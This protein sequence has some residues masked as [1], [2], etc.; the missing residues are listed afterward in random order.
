MAMSLSL[1]VTAGAANLSDYS[2]S[3]KVTDKYATAVDFASQLG[4]LEGFD[5]GKYHPQGTLT[6][7]Q[8]ATMVYRMTTADVADVYTANFA[9]GAAEAFSDTAATAW[10]A[11]YVGYAADAELLKGLGDGTYAPNDALTGY[12]ALAA[13]LRGVG[14]DEPGH[15]FVGADWTVEV[16]KVA[17]EAG[18]LSGISNVD[19][20]KPITREVA[21]QMIYNIMFA[22]MVEYTPA[23][24]Y[25]EW[26][27]GDIDLA[28]EEFNIVSDKDGDAANVAPWGRPATIWVADDGSDVT[29]AVT[30]E[31]TPVATY[32]TGVNECDLSKELGKT[33]E[34]TAVKWENGGKGSATIQATDVKNDVAGT[35][36]G[37]LTEVYKVGSAYE[38]VEIQTWLAEVDAV[39]KATFDKNGHVTRDAKTTLKAYDNQNVAPEVTV[40]F[41][42]E[43]E[44]FAEDSYVLMN[45]SWFTKAA[46]TVTVGDSVYE[47]ELEAGVDTG[48][49]NLTAATPVATGELTAYNNTTKTS[50]IGGTTYD[51]AQ[52]FGMGFVGETGKTYDVYVD[53]YG[54]VIGI[55]V[56]A[57]VYT[58]GIV[59]EMAWENS[60]QTLNTAKAYANLLDFTATPDKGVVMAGVANE[61]A[62]KGYDKFISA[63]KAYAEGAALLAER[64]VSTIVENNGD[65]YNAIYKFETLSDGSKVIAAEFD[66]TVTKNIEKNVPTNVAAGINTNDNTVYLV[67]TGNADDGYTYTTYTGYKTI[68]SMNN[69]V[70]DYVIDGNYVAYMYVDATGENVVFPGS[71]VVAV[72]A[73]NTI[74]GMIGDLNVYYMYIN[75][76]KVAQT[77]D[78]TLAEVGFTSGGIYKVSFDADGVI[79]AVVPA[80]N[81]EGLLATIDTAADCEGTVIEEVGSA[82]AYNCEGAPVYLVASDLSITV[83]DYDDVDGKVV[84]VVLNDDGDKAVAMYVVNF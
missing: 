64:T 55:K 1:A 31:A 59:T 62:A 41:Y 9:G 26:M 45:N 3:D 61:Q 37:V 12:A 5:D 29:A 81:V 2:D 72:I 69:V 46:G 20:N 47:P 67:K 6:R 42:A 78:K 13:F 53:F 56:P 80:L 27:T 36:Q 73:D 24:G 23:F 16:A 4:I 10:Y 54:N 21:A 57:T 52:K 34:W 11:G 49:L 17:K 15:N 7:A 38:I 18:A 58:Y 48:V 68:P 32:K 40:N 74:D 22:K 44:A 66:Q 83:G 35:A 28:F 76:E 33:G 14:Y 39:V 70:V 25:Q 43:T 30:I 75:G 84:Y 60:L 8:L 63:D 65:Y 71:S 51:W 19:L 82:E 79:T 77:C 50:T